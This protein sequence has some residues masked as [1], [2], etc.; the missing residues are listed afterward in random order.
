MHF[1]PHDLFFV[2]VHFTQG[3]TTKKRSDRKRKKM[4]FSIHRIIQFALGAMIFDGGP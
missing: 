3:E 2:G 1:F 4:A